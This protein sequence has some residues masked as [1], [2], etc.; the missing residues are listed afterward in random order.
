MHNG[1]VSVKE[2]VLPFAR[3]AGADSVL[4]PE[5]KS[6]GEVMG[7]AGDFPTAFGK[8]QAAAGVTLP[9]EGTV[10]I[11]VTDNDKAAATQPRDALSRSRLRDHRHQG[12]RT[13]DP[14]MGI[15]VRAINKIAEGLPHVVDFIRNREVDLNQHAHRQR[16][17]VGR[18]RDPQRGGAQRDSLPHDDDRRLRGR[19]RDL[20]SA[21]AWAEPPSLQELHEVRSPQSA[22]RRHGAVTERVLAP[23]GRR[24]CEVVA[25]EASGDTALSPQW[26]RAAPPPRA[27][28]F[29]M[30]AADG[31]GGPNGRPYLPRARRRRGGG[32]S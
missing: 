12:H 32:G 14:R 30:L 31:W 23:F 13:G 24:R 6:T 18:L 3:F 17:P 19:T 15:P 29:Y 5:M 28:Q 25:N 7:I 9:T 22:V 1:H 20:R 4:G 21:R 16:R 27:G 2:A 8:A 26:T 11:T 10:F